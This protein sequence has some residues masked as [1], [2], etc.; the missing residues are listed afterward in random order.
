MRR[1][2]AALVLGLVA[3]AA[4]ACSPQR[5][6]APRL[7][8]QVVET[9]TPAIPPGAVGNGPSLSAEQGLSLVAHAY[10]LIL[11]QYVDLVEPV[12]LMRAALE[13]EFAALPAGQP[14]PE[15]PTFVGNNPGADTNRFGR[16]YLEAANAAG[17]GI[18][19]QAALTHA[20]IRKMAASAGDCH[21]VFSDPA[22]MTDQAART[23]GDVRFG[24]VGIRIKRPP[25]EPLLVYELLDGG[26]ASKA[27]VKPGDAVLKVDGY[28]TTSLPL[29]QVANLIRGREGTQVKLTIQRAEGKKVQDVTLKRV[30][31]VEPVF[32]SKWLAGNVA[33]LRLNSFSKAGEVQLLDTIRSFEARN[34]KGWVIDLRTNGGGELSAVLSIMSKFL[35]DGPF[36]YEV[37]RQGRRAAFGPDGSY[38][39]RQHPLVVLVSDSTASGAE[40]FAAAV[41]HYRAGTVVGNKTAGCAGIANR[42]PLED[43]SGLSVTVEKLLGPAGE[44]LNKAGVR[45]RE[46][47]EVSRADLAAGK[48]PPLQRALSLLGTK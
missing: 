2:S 9:P 28:D 1:P 13:G 24:G 45:P 11:G 21:T 41:Q 25:N 3:L 10:N 6:L 33:Y 19:R 42:F 40:L 39:P 5:A 37:D 17:P 4:A 20:A 30:S 14:Q 48:D 38:L 18:E 8:S 26:S 7:T 15:M 44:E 47:V 32:Q 34:P 36:G 43:G 35:K 23:Q 46:T 27:G 29:D 22:Q 31:V 12:S 16:A